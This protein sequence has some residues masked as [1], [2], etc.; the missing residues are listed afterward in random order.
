MLRNCSLLFSFISLIG[1]L[2]CN[3]PVPSKCSKSKAYQHAMKSLIQIQQHNAAALKGTGPIAADEATQKGWLDTFS[4]WASSTQEY[5]TALAQDTGIS[6][7][8][9]TAQD[10]AAQYAAAAKVFIDDSINNPS[11]L[12]SSVT[13]QFM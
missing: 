5:L 4:D 11:S 8:V 1:L 3:P 6:A 9:K 13:A 10:Y 7:A 12:T 2:G